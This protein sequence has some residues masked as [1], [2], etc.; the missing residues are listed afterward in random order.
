MFGVNRKEWEKAPSKAGTKP[1][2]QRQAKIVVNNTHWIGTIPEDLKGT[3]DETTFADMCAGFEMDLQ[4]FPTS[5]LSRKET[6][7]D[8]DLILLVEQLISDDPK[9]VARAATT[10]NELASG[11]EAMSAMIRIKL[12]A[13]PNAIKNIFHVRL[14]VLPSAELLQCF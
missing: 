6:F 5:A 12:L 11:N 1:A 13:D 4:Y 7:R 9:V 14:N 2:V 10:L 8:G 3:V